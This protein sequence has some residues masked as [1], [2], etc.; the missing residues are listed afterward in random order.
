MRRCIRFY[1]DGRIC[2]KFDSV[3]VIVI[4]FSRRVVTP[5]NSS[6]V[7]FDAATL[8][9]PVAA[10]FL[11]GM[12]PRAPQLRHLTMLTLAAASTA[13]STPS[14]GYPPLDS[15]GVACRGDDE[16]S[17]PAILNLSSLV[18]AGV[19]RGSHPFVLMKQC[20]LYLGWLLVSYWG[21]RIS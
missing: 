20:P 6:E 12:V 13:W 9:I 4:C 2:R 17:F 1:I 7:A 8:A 19:K 11:C 3:D 16:N 18:P 15:S 21:F 10:S 14:F 5:P